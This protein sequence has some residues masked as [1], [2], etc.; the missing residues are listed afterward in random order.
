MKNINILV[1]VMMLISVS[2]LAGCGKEPELIMSN[3]TTAYEETQAEAD[4]TGKQIIYV[5]ITGAVV[6]PGLYE[7]HSGARLF[8]AVNMAGGFLEDA[9]EAYANLAMPISDGEQ[10]CIYTVAETETMKNN[11]ESIGDG[12]YDSAGRLDIN[13][14]SSD[15]LQTLP[16]VGAAK[17][18]AIIAYREDNGSFESVESIKEVTGIGDSIY[19]QIK[20]YITVR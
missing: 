10:Y 6:N 2:L 3:E 9:D 7:L 16:G 8:D 17:A 13:L 15:E 18:G 1:A 11:T 19:N 4:V 12:H 14:A 5:H 20:D